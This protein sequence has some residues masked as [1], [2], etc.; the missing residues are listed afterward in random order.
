MSVHNQKVLNHNFTI[1][2]IIRIFIDWFD[3]NH[4]SSIICFNIDNI[5]VN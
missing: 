5:S 2:N 3:I 1:E 4:D